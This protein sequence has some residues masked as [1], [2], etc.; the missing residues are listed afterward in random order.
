MFGFSGSD[1]RVCRHGDGLVTM[2]LP[3]GWPVHRDFCNR[4]LPT[5]GGSFQ[6]REIVSCELQAI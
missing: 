6:A 4:L 1:T 3:L 2:P 5:S